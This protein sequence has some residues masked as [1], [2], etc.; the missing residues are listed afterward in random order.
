MFALSTIQ[1]AVI[2]PAV[3]FLAVWVLQCAMLNP[4]AFAQYDDGPTKY[5]WSDQPEYSS[6]H[7]NP[8]PG[9]DGYNAYQRQQEQMD[10]QRQQSLEIDRQRQ[11]NSE[12]HSLGYRPPSVTILPNGKSM[13]CYGPTTGSPVSTCY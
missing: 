1:R 12:D 5:P 11:R 8:A 9:H 3:L 2:L 6:P 4:H 7:G 13:T 10:R